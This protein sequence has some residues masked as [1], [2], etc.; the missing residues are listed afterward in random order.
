MYMMISA[1]PPLTAR[2]ASADSVPRY[3]RRLTPAKGDV[4]WYSITAY[5]VG[6]GVDEPSPMDVPFL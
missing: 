1:M 4:A 3:C 6:R 5:V 2:A